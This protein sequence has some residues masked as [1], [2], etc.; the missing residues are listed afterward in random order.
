M[1]SGAPATAGAPSSIQCSP[2]TGFRAGGSFGLP[3]W[4]RKPGFSSGRAGRNEGFFLAFVADSNPLAT[5]I[6]FGSL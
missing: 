5:L 6:S 2:P 3:P 4:L 1:R